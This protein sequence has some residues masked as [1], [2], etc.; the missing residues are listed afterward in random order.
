MTEEARRVT[1]FGRIS[2]NTSIEWLGTPV[3]FMILPGCLGLTISWSLNCTGK[4]E[5]PTN[6]GLW[7]LNIDLVL[8]EEASLGLAL[9]LSVPI[10][11]PVIR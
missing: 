1:T 4:M 2:I 5:I 3:P 7:K 9:P 11:F 10:T 8:E 6:V